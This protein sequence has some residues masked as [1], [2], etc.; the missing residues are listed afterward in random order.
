MNEMYV[1][2]NVPFLSAKVKVA[3]KPFLVFAPSVLKVK[4]T[5]LVFD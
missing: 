3:L 5:L 1:N 4:M 2:R